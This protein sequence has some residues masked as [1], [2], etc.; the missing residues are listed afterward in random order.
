LLFGLLRFRFF[1]FVPFVLLCHA[2]LR[3]TP[4]S[5]QPAA[6]YPPSATIEVERIEGRSMVN[7]TGPDGKR[8]G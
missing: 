2:V 1:H 4:L 6:L 8:Q 5:H 3:D 7:R